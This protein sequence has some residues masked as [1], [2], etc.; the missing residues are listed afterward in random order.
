MA[1]AAAKWGYEEEIQLLNLLEELD[2]E[3]PAAEQ[4]D[5]TAGRGTASEIENVVSEP[6]A[7]RDAPAV[8]AGYP[9]R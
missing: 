7:Q 1:K 2:A 5:H 4:R 8:P 6:D 9:P 3:T